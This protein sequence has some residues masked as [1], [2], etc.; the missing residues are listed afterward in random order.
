M[1]H[2]I[3]LFVLLAGP[4][5]VPAKGSAPSKAPAVKLPAVPKV[6]VP[7]LPSPGLAKPAKPLATKGKLKPMRPRAFYKLRRRLRQAQ[8]AQA[9]LRVLKRGLKKWHVDL[10]QSEL[11]IKGFKGEQVRI[12]AFK[13]I[14]PKMVSKRQ[15]MVGWWAVDGANFRPAQVRRFQ[16]LFHSKNGKSIVDFGGSQLKP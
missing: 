15:G 1:T 12:A 9:R 16:G 14:R 6:N 11:L 7:K 4:S 13:V 10:N 2:V 3:G 8:G 5:S